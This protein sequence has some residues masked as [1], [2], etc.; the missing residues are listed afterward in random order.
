[1]HAKFFTLTTTLLAFTG[2]TFASPLRGQIREP[3]SAGLVNSYLSDIDS[4][5][6]AALAEELR[7][8]KAAVGLAARLNVEVEVPESLPST[9]N[10]LEPGLSSTDLSTCYENNPP[11]FIGKKW[12]GKDNKLVTNTCP[13]DAS[14]TSGSSKY[15]AVIR[16]YVYQHTLQATH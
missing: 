2:L 14:A 4:S 16:A 11:E 6:V 8:K 3:L 9:R 10:I 1:M 13:S 15:Y 7:L 12:R 5:P